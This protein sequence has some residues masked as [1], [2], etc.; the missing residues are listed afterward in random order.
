MLRV[1]LVGLYMTDAVRRVVTESLLPLLLQWLS[2]LCVARKEGKKLVAWTAREQLARDE[3]VPVPVLVPPASHLHHTHM[4]CDWG[5]T[6][7]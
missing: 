1:E 2:S 6:C 5:R 7:L 4:G 3:Y